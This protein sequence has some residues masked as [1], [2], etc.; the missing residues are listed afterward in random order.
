MSSTTPDYEKLGAFYLGRRMDAADSAPSEENVLYDSKDLTTHAVCVGMT[1]SGKTGL[2]VTLLEEAAIDGIPAIVIDPKGDLGNLLLTFPE[3]RAEDFRPWVDEAEAA[4]KGRSPDEHARKTAELWRSG[5]AQW[6]EDGERVRRFRE[7]ADVAVYT[8]GS[9]AGL[10]LAVLRSFEAPPATLVADGDALRERV[11]GA[12][13]GLLALLGLDADPLRSRDHVLLSALV[14]AAW[15]EGRSLDLPRLIREVQ[16]PPFEQ[17]GVFDLET[18]YPSSDRLELAMRLNTL[19][20]SPGFEQWMKGEPLDVARLL[21]DEKGR[22]RISILN[23]AHLSDAERMFFVTILLNEVVTWMRQQPGTSSL[24]ALLYMDEVFGY[25]PPT[26]N[27]PSKRPMLTL[28]KQARAFGLGCVLAT[29]NPVDLDYKALSNAGTWFLGRLQTERDKMRVIEGLESAAAGTRMSRPELERLISS[30]D[31]RVF[32]MNNVHDDEPTL[33]HVRWVLSYL[34]GPLTREQIRTLMADR[35]A[36]AAPAAVPADLAKAA[37]AAPAASAAAPTA[38]LPEPPAEQLPPDVPQLWLEPRAPVPA[39]ARLV[40][41]PALFA[42][43]E[44]HHVRASASLDEWSRVALLADAPRGKSRNVDWDGARR[45]EAASLAVATTAPAPGAQAAVPAALKNPKAYDSWAKSL[46]GDLY[47]TE[48]LTLWSCKDPK[49][50]SGHRESEA[51]FRA[52]LAQLDREERDLDAEKLKASYDTKFRRLQERIR[53]AEAR[54]EKEREQY[55][56]SKMQA[57]ISVGATLLGALLGRKAVSKSSLGKATTALRGASRASREKED[58]GR[59]EDTLEALREEL[60][61]LEAQFGS[62][63]EELRA[64]ADPAAFELKEVVVAPRKSDLNVERV[65]LAWTPWS[66]DSAGI[67]EPLV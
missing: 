19:F 18:F 31:S 1:G 2:C 35:K 64:P 23:I 41:R 13:S 11:Q 28:L 17:V 9:S 14:E 37:A 5:L 49:A 43:A 10:S 15:R 4:R 44:L 36:A 65:A 40:W 16:A 54:V 67:A 50:Q 55:G 58:I 26:A 59:A 62:E 52:R 45:L 63:A 66:V 39:G 61:A 24:R 22:P 56:Q 33:F 34:R 32:L 6:G 46:K 12:V 47:R 25:L 53:K 21:R 29:Q 42:E 8:P 7:A 51:D 38:A 20:A 48:A 60:A 27:P 57:A 30:L 3:L